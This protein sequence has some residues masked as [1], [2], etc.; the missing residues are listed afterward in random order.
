MPDPT[1]SWQRLSP[2]DA[3]SWLAEARAAQGWEV[4]NDDFA[5]EIDDGTALTW[6]RR[7]DGLVAVVTA[8]AGAVTADAASQAAATPGIA[9]AP[10]GELVR[11]RLNVAVSPIDSPDA[12]A[13]VE[14][15]AAISAPALDPPLHLP[16]DVTWYALHAPT[17]IATATSDTGW[18]PGRSLLKMSKD[19]APV[20]Q[21]PLPDGFVYERF[22]VVQDSAALL[23]VNAAAFASHPEQGQ[24]SLAAFTRKFAGPEFTEEGVVL[25]K[26][27]A[28]SQLAAFCWTK[29]HQP[30]ES[31]IDGEIYV[32]GVDPEY[33]GLGLGRAATVSGLSRLAQQGAHRFVLFVEADNHSAIA[34]YESLGFAP[35]RRD[36]VFSRTIKT[37][38]HV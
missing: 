12:P 7:S 22:D 6:M 15:A 32:I 9:S 16:V 11:P 5:V 10:S 3:R 29:L 13:A 25:I 20:A 36:F 27:A 23:T 31:R 24:M 4:V 30:R 1:P 21:P 2:A 26:Q 18:Q 38:P 17:D 34:L 35:I 8:T 37:E 19:A 14:Q 33:Q 28:S